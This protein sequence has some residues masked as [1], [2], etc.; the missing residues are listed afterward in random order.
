MWS[1][2]GPPGIGESSL[3]LLQGVQ[4]LRGPASL[5]FCRGTF[6]QGYQCLKCKAGAHKECLE[7]IPPC[8][9]SKCSKHTAVGWLK[10]PLRPASP[11]NRAGLCLLP[12]YQL[13]SPGEAERLGCPLHCPRKVWWATHGD[14]FGAVLSKS[15][16]FPAIKGT[17]RSNGCLLILVEWLR[18]PRAASS[19]GVPV[20][21]SP[22]PEGQSSC[23]DTSV[24][25]L[26]RGFCMS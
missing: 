15:T 17:I 11:E 6:Y 19:L 21:L 1:P 25:Q 10:S 3:L 20:N 23:R 13:V 5:S 16:H 8:K 9:F 22:V 14:R 7:V 4:Y 26:F 2:Q 18:P 24:L 12:G